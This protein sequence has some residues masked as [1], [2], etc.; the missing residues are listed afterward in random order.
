MLAYG[1]RI[2]ALHVPFGA[3]NLS[4]TPRVRQVA[5]DDVTIVRALL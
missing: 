2:S 5:C 1:T 3:R 4:Y